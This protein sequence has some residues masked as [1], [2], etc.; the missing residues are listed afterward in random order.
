MSSTSKENELY[1]IDYL[2]LDFG[3]LPDSNNLRLWLTEK[4]QLNNNNIIIMDLNTSLMSTSEWDV[5]LD[6]I[7]LAKRCITL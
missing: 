1:N 5:V 3:L 4:Q 2:A 7:L 6:N